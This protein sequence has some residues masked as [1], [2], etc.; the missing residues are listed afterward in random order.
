M[1]KEDE[2]IKKTDE[3]NMVKEETR[4]YEIKTNK[5]KKKIII[6]SVCIGVIILLTLI[7]STVF[8]LINISNVNIISGIKINGIEISNFSKEEAIK[9]LQEITNQKLE[10]DII[11]KTED[12]E[13]GIKLSQIETNYN[14]QKALEEAYNIGRDSNIF[15]NNYNILETVI[16]GKEIDLEY[17]YNEELLNNILIDINSKLPNSVI[18]ANYYIE[19]EKLI[20]TKGKK[21]TSI[22]KDEIKQ[23]LI[24]EILSN[25]KE[26]QINMDLIEKEPLPIDIDKIYKEVHKDPQNAYYTKNPFQVF[27]HVEGV[28]FDLEAARELLKEDKEEYEIQLTI[29]TPEVTTNKIGTEAFPDLLSSFSTRYDA[30]NYPRTTNLKLAM[31]KLN[32]V[33][34]GAGETF[35]YN[36]TLGKRT[37]EAGY[38]E[39]GGYAG[40]RVVQT[41]AGGICQISSTLYD[42]VVYANLDIVERHNHMFL[43]GYVG[44]GKD[45]TVVY[46]SLDFKFKNTRKYPIM[47]KT[48]IGNGVAKIDIYGI[49]QEVEYDVDIATSV[50][51]YTPFKVIYEEDK[52]LQPGQEKVAQNGMN[53]CKSITYKVVKLNGVEV[54]REVLSSDTYDPMNKIIKKGPEKTVETNT[55]VTTNTEKETGKTET[56]KKEETSTETQK[57]TQTTKPNKDSE[58]KTNTN[59]TKPDKEL[60]SKPNTNTT[61][62]DKDSQ[63]KPSTSIKPDKESQIKPSTD[64][65]Q[66]PSMPNPDKETNS[67]Q[68][69]GIEIQENV[70]ETS[71]D[72]D[73]IVNEGQ[74]EDKRSTSE[75]L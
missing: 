68:I 33:V 14:I 35:S 55:D 10:N 18:E 73:P 67:E 43:A 51:S 37:A 74:V 5:S 16:F 41:L 59:T 15:A 9:K 6:A 58:S 24:N 45:A 48:S 42:A 38:R 60:Q 8:A 27:P 66:K 28:N 69:T 32:G 61:K 72:L 21:G 52:T 39:A 25:N 70:E 46:G 4:T 64:T 30:S 54:S 36:K 75:I 31:G 23:A 65:T 17:T 29:I 2:N 62:P 57:P 49:K 3:E 50:L 22:N 26:V 12:F 63:T 11:V 7:F 34:L 1:K 19:N 44:A 20:I 47:I 40:G 71:I 53:G 56:N 13:Y